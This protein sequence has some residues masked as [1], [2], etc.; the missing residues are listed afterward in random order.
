L[1]RPY[2]FRIGR[3]GV[4]RGDRL[5]LHRL[6]TA[7]ETFDR[8]EVGPGLDRPGHLPLAAVLGDRERLAGGRDVERVDLVARSNFSSVLSRKS[9][10]VR[11]NDVSCAAAIRNTF[12]SSLR[13]AKKSPPVGVLSPMNSLR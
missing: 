11:L 13:L 12:F 8:S 5:H 6:E 7:D 3:R 2:F 4:V 1:S 10:V 9:K